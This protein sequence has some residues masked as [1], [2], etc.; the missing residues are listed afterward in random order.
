MPGSD[1]N[2]HSP[3]HP[4]LKQQRKGASIAEVLCFVDN[5][6]CGFS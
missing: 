6:K 1:T 5:S 3:V 4:V 2:D